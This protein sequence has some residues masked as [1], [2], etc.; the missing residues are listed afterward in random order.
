MKELNM[1]PEKV[2][3]ILRPLFPI[4]QDDALWDD[5]MTYAKNIRADAVMAFSTHLEANHPDLNTLRERLP[6]FAKR[7]AEVR[8]AGISPMVNYYVTMGHANM[9]PAEHA[10]TFTDMVDGNGRVES[11]CP[12]PLCPEFKQYIV[13]G[14]ALFASLDVDG[15]W[16]DDDFR[17]FGRAVTSSFLC[18]CDR[19]LEAFA[20][21]T[22]TAYGR[23]EINVTLLKDP[24]SC[25][26]AELQLRRDWRAFQEDVLVG[27]AVS[28]REACESVNPN[29]HMGLMTNTIEMMQRHG[30]HLDAEIRALRTVSHPQPYVRIG[31]ASYTDEHLP[32]IL[33][34]CVTFDAMAATITEPC[35]V[36]SEIEQFPW[37]IGGK[38]ARGLALELYTLT[39]SFSPLLTLSINDGF[40]GFHDYSG[41]YQRTLGPLKPYLQAVTDALSGKKRR[42]ASLP[43]SSD[44]GVSAG[45][46]L[47]GE[48]SMRMN[49]SLTR[50]GIPVAPGVQTPTL[51]T[52]KEAMAYTEA[53]IVGWL[54]KGAIVTSEAYYHLC[55][56]G[57][58]P[59]SPIQVEKGD[60]SHR[61]AVERIVAPQAP[62]WLHHKDV[63]SWLYIPVHAGYIVS[64]GE[65]AEV[66]S[67]IYDNL[68]N[69][70]SAGVVVTKEPY[71]MAVVAHTGDLL[72][73]TGRQWLYQHILSYLTNGEYPAMVEFGVNIYPVWWEDDTEALLGL[74]NFSMETYPSLSLWIPTSR[75]LAKVEQLSRE[76]LWME[77]DGIVAAH[78]DG[79]IRLTLQGDSVP[80]HASFETYRLAFLH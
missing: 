36:G 14:Y 55:E 34:R 69:R 52:M 71:P 22:G 77:A 59:G 31:G 33:D 37:T 23:E 54:E 45:M 62:D 48:P 12:C 44:P 13:D 7:F 40:L 20:A 68:G 70:Q 42:G 57:M 41:S 39:V 79:G 76:G 74:T 3:Y 80:D 28:L 29:I 2:Q 10:K 4:L 67:E 35:Q 49:H 46:N 15:V 51:I 58:M 72:K 5:F 17:L 75:E 73:E 60:M 27:L 43:F 64:A 16:I 32:G 1:Q 47:S 61:T 78:P 19:H 53:T 50:I 6:L 56:R 11:G 8:A 18:F 26:T 66:W 38:S 65:G 9:L 21:R 24:L 30:R 25:T 63:V